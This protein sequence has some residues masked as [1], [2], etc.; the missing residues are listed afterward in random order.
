MLEYAFRS[1]T[2]VPF[3]VGIDIAKV[4]QTSEIYDIGRGYKG[5]IHVKSTVPPTVMFRTS[6]PHLQDRI[7][8]L[9]TGAFY[10]TASTWFS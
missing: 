3:S 1:N 10:P 4:L 9:F 2:T 6:M 8:L 5:G 7:D